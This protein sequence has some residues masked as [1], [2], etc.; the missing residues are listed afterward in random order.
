MNT[1]QQVHYC[2]IEFA[3]SN[4]LLYKAL[5][6]MASKAMEEQREPSVHEYNAL[7]W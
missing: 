7:L 1:L 2:V 5:V 3:V 6:K 4:E